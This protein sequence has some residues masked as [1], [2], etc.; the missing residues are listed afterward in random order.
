[1]G[2]RKNLSKH[3]SSRQLGA[4]KDYEHL[5]LKIHYCYT[6]TQFYLHMIFI[7][8]VLS[9]C[10]TSVQKTWLVTLW[11]MKMPFQK[12]F[13]FLL[14]YR[15]AMAISHSDSWHS[16][17]A[18][19]DFWHRLEFSDHILELVDDKS[20]LLLKSL[21]LWQFLFAAGGWMRPK[22]LLI[23]KVK[24]ETFL[25]CWRQNKGNLIERCLKHWCWLFLNNKLAPLHKSEDDNVNLTY[26]YSFASP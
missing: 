15:Q 8:P 2:R 9:L 23:Q 3:E 10:L 22:Y 25:H 18:F 14:V 21:C 24:L 5:R 16:S 20:T 13:L 17:T 12:L 11:F 26:M 19:S 1:M 7:F 6:S 4:L